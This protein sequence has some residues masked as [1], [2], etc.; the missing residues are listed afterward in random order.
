MRVFIIAAQTADGLIGTDA[1][2][3][4]LEWRSKAD[5]KSF[6]ELTRAAGVLVMGATTYRTFR[7]KRAPPGRQLFVYTHHPETIFGEGVQT[8]NEEPQALVKRLAAEGN[9]G[10]AVCGGA[11]INSLFLD[12]GLVDELYLTI[13]PVLFG[14]GIPLLRHPIQRR[15]SLIECKQLTDHTLRLHYAVEK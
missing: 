7:L 11:S 13:E 8:T 4:A 3:S 5:G 10:L 12:A 1:S 6:G 15:L 2:Q 9:A 14:A